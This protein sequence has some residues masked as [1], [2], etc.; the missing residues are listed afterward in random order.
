LALAVVLG[1]AQAG[2]GADF[3][4]LGLDFE[5]MGLSADGKTA[6]GRAANLPHRWTLSTGLQP[7]PEDPGGEPRGQANAASSDGSI[8]VGFSSTA[9]IPLNEAVRWVDGGAAFGL[10]E[11]AG[12]AANSEAVD[13]SFDGSV[14]VGKSVANTGVTAFRRT[15]AGGMQS[16]GTLSGTGRSEAFA[17]SGDGAVVVGS[18]TSL[19]PN[20]GLFGEAFR[21]TEA[22]GMKGLGHLPS[23][24]GFVGSVAYDVSQ[25]GGVIVGVSSVLQNSGLE[26]SEAFRWTAESGMVGLGDLDGDGF[27]SAAYGV[28]ADGALIIGS[29]RTA[30]GER[31]FLWDDAHGMR[32]L[33]S[34]LVSD[35]DLGTELAGWTLQS[36]TAISADGMY[37]AGI[38]RNPDGV[39][40]NWYVD[41]NAALVTGDANGD[42]KV[43]LADFGILK[44][45]FGSGTTLAQ[46]DFTGDGKVDLSD[47][48]ILKDNF[49]NSGAVATPEPSGLALAGLAA[50][51]AG[52]AQLRRRTA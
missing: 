39:L 6:V 13:V 42:G 5:L 21:W 44:D 2:W 18:V 19:A 23:A 15:E 20:S 38:G 17:V 52:L 51:A 36:A 41:L 10:G 47:F 3:L 49:G 29:G 4:G 11:L 22:D 37:L 25:N 14:I 32:D 50:V 28:S 31:A 7:L 12:G 16:L 24:T 30:G 46:G 48:G 35:Y 8:I 40:E 26:R 34:F 43:D 27:Y 1:S 45:N 33:Q 9:A